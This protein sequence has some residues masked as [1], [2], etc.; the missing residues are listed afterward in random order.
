[1][2]KP[3]RR[4]YIVS[5]W[6]TVRISSMGSGLCSISCCITTANTSEVYTLRSA[7]HKLVAAGRKTGGQSDWRGW[8]CHPVPWLFVTGIHSAL[9]EFWFKAGKF[10][11]LIPEW[12]KGQFVICL[13]SF[14]PKA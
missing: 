9:P 4:G 11:K 1:M 2:T 3:P 6:I 14:S 5:D 13:I 7:K 10:L 12:E 8:D